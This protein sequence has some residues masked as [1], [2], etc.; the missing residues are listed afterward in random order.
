MCA[1]TRNQCGARYTA[2]MHFLTRGDPKMTTNV[3]Q[4]SAQIFKFPPRGRFATGGNDSTQ[5]KSAPT[6]TPQP[7]SAA[8]G[9][10]YHDEA[11]RE[12][13]LPRNN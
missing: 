13:E 8:F 12:A 9:A 5:T 10:W 2:Y 4:G 3:P 7:V 11:V 1:F 6:F